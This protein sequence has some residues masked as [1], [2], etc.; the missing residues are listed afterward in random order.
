MH[1]R[2]CLG[3]YK[4]LASSQS[5]HGVSSCSDDVE[6]GEEVCVTRA[7]DQVGDGEE[8]APH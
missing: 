4:A 3:G 2:C 8:I 5:G 7:S 6:W 1:P